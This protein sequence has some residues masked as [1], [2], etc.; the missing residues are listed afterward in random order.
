MTFDIQ[1][2]SPLSKELFFNPKRKNQTLQFLTKTWLNFQNRNFGSISWNVHGPRSRPFLTA[3]L[4]GQ[5][6]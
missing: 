3:I 5:L 4:N 1:S 6:K 2:R